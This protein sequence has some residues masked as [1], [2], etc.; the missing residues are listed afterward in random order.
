LSPDDVAVPDLPAPPSLPVLPARFAA[1]A[2]RGEAWATWLAGLPRL[3]GDLLD[4]WALVPDGP[5]LHGECALVLPVRTE[6][7]RAAGRTAVLKVTWPHWEAETEHIAL[8]RWHGD[9]AVELLRADPRRLALLLERLSTRDLTTVPDDESCAVIAGLYGRLH[10]PAT[11]Q[12]RTLSDCTRDWGERLLALPRSAPVPR[13]YVEQAAAL[14]RAFAADPGTDGTLVHTDL[15][16]QNVLAV[17]HEPTEPHEPVAARG[18][19][20]AIDP[21]PLSGDPHYEV[22]PVLWNRWADAVAT[23][24]LRGALRR[25]LDLVCDA[26]GL[27][28]DRA[29]DWMVCRSM[30]SALWEVEEAAR[31]PG[32]IG[33][34]DR[35]LLTRSVTVVKAVLD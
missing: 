2:T 35:D 9:G 1:L 14:G 20:L 25:R 29:R 21:K 32:G 22:A 28:R 18:P 30:Y 26:A 11:P 16:P 19:W 24:D 33:N 23:G 5:A 8:Q 17:P 4:D 12:L 15:H 7:G 10:V 13:R 27:D 6:P 31:R 34:A 3:V